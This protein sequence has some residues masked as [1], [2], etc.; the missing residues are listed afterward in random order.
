MP[1]RLRPG[2]GRR[3][4]AGASVARG[5]TGVPRWPLDRLRV[6]RVLDRP[7]VYPRTS[8]ALKEKWLISAN[9]GADP[10]WRADGAELF[11]IGA[12]LK[13]MAGAIN[14][15]QASSPAFRPRCFK[16]ASPG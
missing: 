14:E 6:G 13:L 16:R 3:Q 2:L 5:S 15:A 9:G 8:R 1:R 12:D 10:Q 4:S 7:Q 11:F